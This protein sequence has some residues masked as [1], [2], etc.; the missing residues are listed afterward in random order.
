MPYLRRH[1]VSACLAVLGIVGG[2]EA[3]DRGD[4][5]IESQ[6]FGVTTLDPVRYAVAAAGLLGLTLLTSYLPA[7]RAAQVDPV[8]ALRWSDMSLGKPRHRE[9]LD[10]VLATR[11][12]AF[13]R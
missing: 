11:G 6:L 12:G 13:T 8:I 9:A 4:Q 3:G 7:R 1:G 10:A 2:F 5:W